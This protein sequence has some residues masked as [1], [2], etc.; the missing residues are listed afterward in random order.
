MHVRALIMAPGMLSWLMHRV[1][2]N[3]TM[4]QQRERGSTAT[5]EL[6]DC[7]EIDAYCSLV[8]RPK[9]VTRLLKRFAGAGTGTLHL[10]FG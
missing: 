5:H 2:M 7:H 6:A 4:T 10:C 1:K 9:N 8:N 3:S